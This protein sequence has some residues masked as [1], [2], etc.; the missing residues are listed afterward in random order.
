[1]KYYLANMMK[2]LSEVDKKMLQEIYEPR[3]VAIPPVDA[4]CSMCV[5][6]DGEIRIYGCKNRKEWMEF[7]DGVY[8][9]SGDC[10]LSWKEYPYERGITIGAAGYNPNTGRYISVSS[11]PYRADIREAINEKGS[12]ILIGEDGFNGGYRRIKISDLCFEFLKQPQYLESC[13]RWIAISQY[14]DEAFK[15]FPVVC[16]S[17][18]D[19]E[20]WNV[21][22]FKH[23]APVHQRTEDDLGERWQNYS[24]EPSVV[25]L[26]DGTLVMFVRTTQDYHYMHVSYDHGTTW[27][28]EPEPTMFHGTNTMPVLEKLEDGRILFFWCNTEMM[29]EIDHRAAVPP[30]QP[31]ELSGVSEDVFTNRDAN[32]LAISEDDGKTWIG[33]RELFL[34]PIRNRGDFRRAG[35][36]GPGDKSIHQG[37]IIELPYGKILIHFGQH[38]SCT[39]VMILDVNWLYETEREED[40]RYGME[41]LTTHMYL[42]SVLGGYRGLVG[43]CAYNRIEGACMAPDP[44]MNADEALQIARVEDE[45]LVYKKQGCVWNFPSSPVGEVTVRLRVVK[46]GVQISLTDHWHNAFDETVPQKAVFSFAITNADAPADCWTDLTIKYEAEKADIYFNGTYNK[47]IPAS[48]MIP[49]GISYLHIQTLAEECDYEGT[50]IKYLKKR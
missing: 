42:K 24:C 15:K 8:L 45:R 32:H 27:S 19:G 35:V 36:D 21:Q 40:F 22:I 1:M 11:T 23:Y 50:Y 44:D 25:E 9:A 13:N 20:S 12:F 34:S 16:Y 28:E 43:H 4:C 38:T 47:T 17:D 3:V 48:K 29:P 39:R 18:D 37:Q 46:S 14:E 5:T 6:P 30:L 26:S 2:N 31:F 10:G 33:F 49:H 7:S 41:H